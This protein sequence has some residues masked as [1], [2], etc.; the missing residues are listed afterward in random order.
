G[1]RSRSSSATTRHDTDSRHDQNRTLT[2]TAPI[3]DYLDEHGSEINYEQR[4]ALIAPD[5][6]SESAWQQLCFRTNTHPGESSTAAAPGRLLQARRHLF[7][8]LT[9]ADLTDPRHVLAWKDANDRSRY[10]DFSQSLSL[11]QRDALFQHAQELLE[12]LGIDEPVTWEPPEECCR[13]L[14]LPGPRLD[15]IDLRALERLVITEGRQP[16]QAAR[17]LNT[18]VTHVRLALEHIDQSPREWSRH[19]PTAAWK[20][21]ERARTL[22]TPAFFQREYT[23]RGK[24]LTCIARETGISRHVVAEQARAIGL[25][26]YYSQRPVPMDE[27]WLRHQYLDLK[28]STADI[29]AELGTENETVRRRLQQLDIPLRP[30]G[31]RS[32]TVMTAKL[33]TKIPRNIRTVAEGTLHGWLRLHRF[34]IAMAFPNLETA[35]AYL[36][37]H[38]GTLVN[39]FQRLEH[40]LGQTLFL[41][42]AFGKAHRLTTAGKALLRALSKPEVQTLMATAIG[43][44]KITP[45]PDTGTLAAATA[46]LTTRKDPGPLKPFTDIPVAR[47]RITRP[48]LTLLR[49]LLDHQNEEFYGA[50]IQARSGLDT[51]T[52]YPRLKQMEQAGWLTSRPETEESWLNRA[53]VGRGPGRRRTYYTF[54]PEGRR[55]AAHEVLHRE[56]RNRVIPTALQASAIG[57]DVER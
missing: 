7:Q 34:Q 29:A 42:S 33:D 45:P 37:I 35:T 6:I 54:T 50:Q 46:R 19:T 47:I 9:G 10:I 44:D 55:A 15:D 17:L 51:G 53:P 21:R 5:T 32:R 56:T 30:P 24:T 4:R 28:R 3:A 13:G 25:T 22:L 43:P 23:E 1:T 16:S 41:R 57:R 14:D 26:I 48:T 52:L 39:Q 12:D 18:S 11:A 36:N 2:G 20:L 40:D 8:L 38:R 31:V 49:D 27:T